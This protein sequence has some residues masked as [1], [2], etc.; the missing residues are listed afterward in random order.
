MKSP[1]RRPG[2]S[3]P[4]GQ[5]T[6]SRARRYRR[7]TQPGIRMFSLADWKA[8]GNFAGER[9]V[10]LLIGAILLIGLVTFH[11]AMPNGTMLIL[12]GIAADHAP[13]GQ[14]D[15]A[16]AK[17]Y[18]WRSGYA[19]HVLD[20]AGG[21]AE[22]IASTLERVRHDPRVTALY[23]FSGGAYALVNVWNQLKPEERARVKR[24]VIVGAPGITAATFPG[25]A[26]VVIQPDPPEGHMEAPR[27]LLNTMR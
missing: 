27:A 22:Q 3:L 17:Q 13:K 24:L 21:T 6:F 25:A 7:E 2:F 23:G 14:L 12:R 19:A 15:D 1:A 16:S 11:F 18:A 9:K 20:V 8:R 5:G 4:R 10:A 26:E